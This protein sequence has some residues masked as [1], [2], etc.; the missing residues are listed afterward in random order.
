[1][2][3]AQVAPVFGPPQAAPKPEAP[4]PAAPATPALELDVTE[5]VT[6]GD[7]LALDPSE[8]GKLRRAGSANDGSIAG[9]AE[10]DS[11]FTSGALKV[12]VTTATYALV[13]VDAQFGAIH[14]GDFLVSSET[15][16]HAMAAK[17][18]T[19]GTVIGKALEPLESGSG[20]I[21]VLLLAR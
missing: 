20:V 3:G 18:P 5:P 2:S 11:T 12:A 6:A 9:I 8:P 1:M 14:A 4:E 17:T 19:P 15:P 21:R 10:R 7:L 16:G 13:K